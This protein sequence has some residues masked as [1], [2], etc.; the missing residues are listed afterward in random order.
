LLADD[1]AVLEKADNRLRQFKQKKPKKEEA[2]NDA[3]TAQPVVV[4]NRSRSPT[5][6]I[7]NLEVWTLTPRPFAGIDSQERIV[8]EIVSGP[9]L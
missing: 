2:K 5:V 6:E 9:S 3:T 7:R 1:K 4:K 8:Q